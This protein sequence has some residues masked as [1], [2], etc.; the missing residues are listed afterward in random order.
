MVFWYN[1]KSQYAI[2]GYAILSTWTF[3]QLEYFISTVLK[4]EG[5][6]ALCLFAA[7]YGILFIL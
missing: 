6:I 3:W 1:N 7:N 2:G 5:K 4:P